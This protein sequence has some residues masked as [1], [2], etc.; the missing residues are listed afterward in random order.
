M[1][2]PLTYFA[3][4]FSNAIVFLKRKEYITYI[5]I[6]EANIDEIKLSLIRKIREIDKNVKALISSCKCL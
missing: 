6:F 5:F 3:Y 4:Y 1:K 2:G